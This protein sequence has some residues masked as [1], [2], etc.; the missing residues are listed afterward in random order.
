MGW[1]R[2]ADQQIQ[3]FTENAVVEIEKWMT[4]NP[5]VVHV[6]VTFGPQFFCK[7]QLRLDFSFL[8]RYPSRDAKQGL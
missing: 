3:K 6:L 2:I 1:S 7:F 8:E 4:V 5:H